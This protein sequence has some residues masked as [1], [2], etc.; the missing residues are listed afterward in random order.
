MPATA[1]AATICF[2]AACTTTTDTAAPHAVGAS[3]SAEQRASN[4]AA[5]SLV[6]A[7]P[8]TACAAISSACAACT[9]ITD[10]AAPHAVIAA[11]VAYE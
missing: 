1:H 9:N 11:R 7:V 4:A 6:A 2:V 3:R 10:T 8:A 5:T